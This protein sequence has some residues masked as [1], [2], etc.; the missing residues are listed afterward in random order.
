MAFDALILGLGNPG[1]QY[2]ATRHN[3]GFWAVD[4]LIRRAT[5]GAK[6]RRACPPGARI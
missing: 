3:L 4:A 2:A 1:P 5:A 6:R